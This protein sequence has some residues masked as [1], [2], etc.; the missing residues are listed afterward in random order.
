MEMIEFEIKRPYRSTHPD[1]P[2]HSLFEAQGVS[3]GDLSKI[4]ILAADPLKAGDIVSSRN[5]DVLP[6]VTYFTR[7]AYLLTAEPK[8]TH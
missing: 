2:G 4:F 8:P 7:Q 1:Y 6:G 5:L 3:Q